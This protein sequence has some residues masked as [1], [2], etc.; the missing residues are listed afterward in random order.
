MV[1]INTAS[2]CRANYK[3]NIQIYDIGY[4]TY[5]EIPSA[6]TSIPPDFVFKQI[7]FNFSNILYQ[8]LCSALIINAPKSFV[9]ATALATP[10][11]IKWGVAPAVTFVAYKTA[12]GISGTLV[13]NIIRNT[14]NEYY[15]EITIIRVLTALPAGALKYAISGT[16]LDIKALTQRE[17]LIESSKTFNLFVGA[18]NQGH[19]EYIR[20]ESNKAVEE[21]DVVESTKLLVQTEGTDFLLQTL[22]IVYASELGNSK[23]LAGAILKELLI[24]EATIYLLGMTTTAFSILSNQEENG[25][26]RNFNSAKLEDDLSQHTLDNHQS[27]WAING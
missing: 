17:F 19:S 21:V 15:P 1:K 5:F 23:A 7:S 2:N 6:I 10:V 24:T 16:N 18:I 12:A 22:K 26:K 20:Y 14:A 13:S 9:M 3:D 4:D 11:L 27:D 25:S 8:S